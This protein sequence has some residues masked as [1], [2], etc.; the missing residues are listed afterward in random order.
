M[1]PGV[2]FNEAASDDEI[3]KAAMCLPIRI[4]G[5]KTYEDCRNALWGLVALVGADRAIALYERR[6]PSNRC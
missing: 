5:E 4:P 1:N 3:E 2:S 6:S